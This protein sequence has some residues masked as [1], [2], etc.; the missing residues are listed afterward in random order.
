MKKITSL[1]L[2]AVLLLGMAAC[3]SGCESILED[4]VDNYLNEGSANN[5][6]NVPETFKCLGLTITLPGDFKFTDAY[7][8]K[9][10][11]DDYLIRVYSLSKSSITPNEGYAYPTL[12]EV[13]DVIGIFSDPV[14]YKTDGDLLYCDYLT[15]ANNI[16]N[17][18]AISAAEG[19]Q[20]IAFFENEN[21]F[22]AV[23]F[24]S[25]TLDYE[26]AVKPQAMQWAK[27][28]TY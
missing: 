19:T 12:Q 9:I 2:A 1:I 11:N 27:A 15:T 6:P 23:F 4:A 22:W 24:Y 16:S 3:F 5:D 10:S 17:Q 25:S 21:S 14:E 18:Y 26:T 13:F 8:E 7:E 28:I 20:F